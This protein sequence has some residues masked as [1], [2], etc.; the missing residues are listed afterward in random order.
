MVESNTEAAR[1]ARRRSPARRP[2]SVQKAATDSLF[3]GLDRFGLAPIMLLGLAYV[4]HTQ[5]IQPIAAAYANMVAK[6]AENNE[7]LKAAVERNN[8]EDT[9]RVADI[10]AAQAL[11]KQLAEEN[12]ALNTKILEA[13]TNADTARKQI[14]SDTQAVLDRVEKL[15]SKGNE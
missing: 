2:A 1:P 11:N 10:T 14:H 4:G 15:L 13:I 8:A 9:E 7:L 3:K 5:V 6:V 12:R